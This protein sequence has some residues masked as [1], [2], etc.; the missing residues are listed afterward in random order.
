[1]TVEVNMVKLLLGLW[2]EEDGQDV[3]EYTLL[4]AFVALATASFF[5]ASRD[6]ISGINSKMDSRLVVA[7]QAAGN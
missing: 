3:I 4:M 6:S 1:M 7:S 2:H 5:G